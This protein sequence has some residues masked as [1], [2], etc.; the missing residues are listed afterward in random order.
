VSPW[1]R[2]RARDPHEGPTGSGVLQGAGEERGI[3]MRV[4]RGAGGLH[5]AG[6]ERGLPMRVLWGAGGV[7]RG[8]GKSEGSP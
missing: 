7:S 5:G 1:G 6:E 2:G 8:Q 4:L 3:P